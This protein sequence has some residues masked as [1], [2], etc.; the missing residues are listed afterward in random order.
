MLLRN[1]YALT[2]RL[3]RARKGLKQ[4]DLSAE[5]DASYVS[6]LERGA[7]AV[8]IETSGSLASALGIA[9]LT[10]LALAHGAQRGVSAK[11]VLAQAVEELKQLEL[12]DASMPADQA[13]PTH[14]LAA[15]GVETTR[16]VLA[17]KADGMTQAE[18]AR[19]LKLSTSTIGR[20]WLR[21][22]PRQSND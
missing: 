20:H 19:A 4:L 16:A 10:L 1:A 3:L 21:T 8:T 22:D 9:P 11:E 14:P 2:L 12:Y 5:V 6:R 13:E 17:L 7:S 15:K 18:V